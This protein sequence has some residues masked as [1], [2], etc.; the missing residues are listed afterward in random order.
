MIFF[1]FLTSRWLQSFSHKRIF[2]HFILKRVYLNCFIFLSLCSIFKM[3]DHEPVCGQNRLFS[4]SMLALNKI[5]S[6]HINRRCFYYYYF[7][8][9]S[10]WFEF[11]YKTRK[12]EDSRR[13][14]QKRLII[15][16]K[17]KLVNFTYFF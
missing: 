5:Y 10:L 17:Q 4:V 11:I 13:F 7:F 8:L 16:F 9:D 6:D 14:L 3:L 15:K 12:I 2:L 1:S